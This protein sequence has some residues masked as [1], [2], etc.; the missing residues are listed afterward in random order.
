MTGTVITDL[1]RRGAVDPSRVLSGPLR[2][3]GL[4]W[5]DPGRS[6]EVTAEGVEHAL[7]VTAGAGTATVPDDD[8]AQAA[9]DA[10]VPLVEGT[11]L[12]LTLG[13]RTVLTAGT[14]GLEYFHAILAVA[15]RPAGPR[16]AAGRPS[17]PRAEST[18]GTEPSGGEGPTG[19]A[20][21]GAPDVPGVPDVPGRTDGPAANGQ[22]TNGPA[23][24]GP[25]TNDP[26]SSERRKGGESR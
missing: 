18:A 1:R 16:P 4:Q 21:P 11:A 24:D 5:L 22:V 8:P 14:A 3:V 6:T 15:G 26:E 10:G 9:P 20:A 2:A 23:A 13:E 17:P 25:A 12:T 7:Y 19:P